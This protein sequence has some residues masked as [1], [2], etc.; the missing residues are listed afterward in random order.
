MHN[1]NNSTDST[2][3]LEKCFF[4]SL[5]NAKR[6]QWQLVGMCFLLKSEYGPS[7]CIEAALAAGRDEFF[8]KK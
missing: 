6:Q 4:F 5:H 1:E 8:A 7:L 2:P 3:S